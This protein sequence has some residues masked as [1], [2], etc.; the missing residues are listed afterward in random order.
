SPAQLTVW[1]PAGSP[2]T[3]DITATNS[4][5]TSVTSAADRFTYLPFTQLYVMDAYGA[6]HSVPASGSLPAQWNFKIG[7]AVVLLPN[8]SGGYVLDGWGGIHPFG[9][10]L[11]TH[12]GM[13]WPFWDIARG[14]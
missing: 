10:A 3:V 6:L 8:G 7:R 9:A 12:G 2:G 11:G 5:G 13:Y 4:G 1:V 14:I